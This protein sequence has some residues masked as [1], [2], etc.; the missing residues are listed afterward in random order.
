M[1]I[2]V[3]NNADIN[4]QGGRRGSAL[5]AASAAGHLGIVNDSSE[6][7]A[8]INAQGGSYGSAL[9]AASAAGHLG[10]VNTLLENNADIN[11]IRRRLRICPPCSICNGPSR[12]CEDSS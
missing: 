2:L 7:N 11:A 1:K 9:H 12:Y 10:I 8:D 6:N 4:A 5:H 3:E